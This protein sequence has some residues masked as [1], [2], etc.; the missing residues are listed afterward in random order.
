MIARIVHVQLV[1]RDDVLHPILA[2]RHPIPHHGEA[3][4]HS[5]F[6]VV[7]HLTDGVHNSLIYRTSKYARGVLRIHQD[8]IHVGRLESGN[9][10]ADRLLIAPHV[11]ALEY[12]ITAGLPDDEL[13]AVRQDVTREA[14]QH[15]V[16]SFAADTLV[17][18]GHGEAG[19]MTL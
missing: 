14:C 17:H 3:P 8:D 11:P 9:A 16:S 18:H 10:L 19:P 7:T 2:A 1:V 15:L 6:Q 12:G 4:E 13:R 5:D